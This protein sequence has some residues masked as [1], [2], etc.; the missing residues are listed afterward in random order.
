MEISH[1]KA[2]WLMELRADQSL[3]EQERALLDAHL[4]ACTD[5]RSYASDMRE[6]EGALVALM[7]RRWKHAPLP[8]SVPALRKSTLQ[9]RAGVLLAMRRLAMGVVIASFLFSAWHLAISGSQNFGSIPMLAPPVPTP[10]TQSTRTSAPRPDCEMVRYT[11][12]PGDTLEGIAAM[13]STSE[14]EIL[15]VN[16][17]SGG[18]IP[19]GL[20]LIIPGCRPTP[21]GT[22][23]SSEL[24]RTHTPARHLLT[25]T[26]AANY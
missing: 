6:V 5:C 18:P 19:S 26:P 22:I 23:D 1:E 9:A 7:R 24:A 13:F 12:R 2:R 8:L 21:T 15:A 16:N 14:E 11:T 4:R 20:E 25:T 10:S 17:L 3:K